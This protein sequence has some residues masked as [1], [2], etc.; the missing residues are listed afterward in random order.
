MRYPTS[1]MI[2][3]VRSV[4]SRN[5]ETNRYARGSEKKLII[6][7]IAKFTE[8]IYRWMTDRSPSLT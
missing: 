7:E 6:G 4:F 5:P 2:N 3:S 8:G 1:G